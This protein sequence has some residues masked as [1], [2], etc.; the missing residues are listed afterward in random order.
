MSA[1][2]TQQLRIAFVDPPNACGEI[3]PKSSGVHP[4]A[5]LVQR[6]NC[7]FVYKAVALAAAGYDAMILYDTS[8][9][10]CVFM[11]RGV[12]ETTVVSITA[13]AITATAAA[14]LTELAAT[15][16]SITLSQPP[17][18]EF[19]ISEVLIWVL[20]VGVVGLGSVWAGYGKSRGAAVGSAQ[21]SSS[22]GESTDDGV[23]T[24][25]AAGFFVIVASGALLFMFFFLNQWLAALLT[26]L[27]SFMMWQASTL[28][29]ATFFHISCPREWYTARISLPFTVA[30]PPILDFA[31]V[32]IASAATATW[33]ILHIMG[34]HWAWIFQNYL[35]AC[36]VL[37]FLGF[38]RLPN[39]KVASILLGSA[40]CYDVFWVFLQPLLFGGPSVMVEVATGG[41][42]GARIPILFEIP[43]L[44]G[45]GTNPAMGMLGL[46]DVV[47]PGLVVAL[48]M[49]WDVHTGRSLF[50]FGNNDNGRRLSQSESAG[51]RKGR[52]YFLPMIA[53][54]GAGLLLTF[55]ALAY[56]WGGDQGQP[57]LLY[58]VPCTMAT[59][60]GLGWRRGELDKLWDWEERENV[61]RPLG[62]DLEAGERRENNNIRGG[63]GASNHSSA[64]GSSASSHSSSSN[65]GGEGLEEG[66][67]ETETAPLLGR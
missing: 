24:T 47:L 4:Q 27:L 30:P 41:R 21:P 64:S 29:T 52:S 39:I 40:L 12:N 15:G 36:L 1:T 57:A 66:E 22:S 9:D 54:Y 59:I 3:S 20:A 60:I 13:A 46:G 51:E 23:I 26:G 11:G 7:S 6:G 53:A 62:H 8:T 45:L 61:E 55:V 49:R 35:C 63:G 38:I 58:L 33:L 19:D 10:D 14:I 65:D 37:L 32:S 28:V 17:Q 18:S 50:S 67:R 2:A 16:G 44:N 34:S 25:R 5:A 48:A 42:S 43:R 56:S 31:A